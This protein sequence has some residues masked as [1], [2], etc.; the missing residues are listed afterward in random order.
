MVKGKTTSGFEFEI[1]DG[2]AKD[3]RFIKAYSMIKSGDQEKALDG[4]IKLVSVIFSNEAEEERLYE[5]LAKQNEGRVPMDVL[6]AELDDIIA[7]MKQDPDLK[8]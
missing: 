4:A 7:S 6:F 1:P 2:L 5:H 3:F 8:N